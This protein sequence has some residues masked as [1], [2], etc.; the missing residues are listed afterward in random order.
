MSKWYASFG[1]LSNMGSKSP[2][3]T[4]SIVYGPF[5]YTET[6]PIFRGLNIQKKKTMECKKKG[7]IKLLL[8]F[9]A[10]RLNLMYLVLM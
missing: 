9:R 6:F 7:Y 10:L 3:Y 2:H 8:I 1:L 5:E 4:G